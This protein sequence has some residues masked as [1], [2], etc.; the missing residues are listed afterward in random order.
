MQ[1]VQ[2]HEGIDVGVEDDGRALA[3]HEDVVEHERVSCQLWMLW[4]GFDV[5]ASGQAGHKGVVTADER[6]LRA[7][8][9]YDAARNQG[10]ERAVLDHRVA[11]VVVDARRLRFLFI[12]FRGSAAS[13]GAPLYEAR[14]IRHL[15]DAGRLGLLAMFLIWILEDVLVDALH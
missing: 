11:L 8:L 4:S 2:G 15:I 14:R 3:D 9:S 10:V 5:Q 6:R 13:E 1:L 7:Q 12:S